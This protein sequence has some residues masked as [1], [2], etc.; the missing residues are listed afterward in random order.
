MSLF[1]LPA[2]NSLGC[3]I[4][5]SSHETTIGIIASLLL[6]VASLWPCGARLWSRSNSRKVNF[7]RTVCFPVILLLALWSVSSIKWSF[8]LSWLDTRLHN[9]CLDLTIH[10]I[11]GR[12]SDRDCPMLSLHGGSVVALLG[13][14]LLDLRASIVV[15]YEWFLS[16]LL[17][18]FRN[19]QVH[20]VVWR[21]LYGIHLFRLSA[22]WWLS[23]SSTHILCAIAKLI[24]W[25]ICHVVGVV[26]S[27][28]P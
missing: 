15:G 12:L 25:H 13:R 28:A 19:I 17:V 22:C 21:L 11:L 24:R 27:S 26:A 23:V 6:V 18:K 16:I 3:I 9:H 2:I 1:E 10:W 20:W 5:P 14:V 8:L 4:I 7:V